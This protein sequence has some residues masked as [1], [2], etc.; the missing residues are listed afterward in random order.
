MTTRPVPVRADA[1]IAG[2]VTPGSRLVGQ[3]CPRCR[4]SFEVG[5]TVEVVDGSRRVVVHRVCP[6]AEPPAPKVTEKK[7]RRRRW[8]AM[9]DPL[10]LSPAERAAYEEGRW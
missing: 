1:A 3:P 2:T 5:A 4:W 9:G 10:A 7:E 6:R 8:D